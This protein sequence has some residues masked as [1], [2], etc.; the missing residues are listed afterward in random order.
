MSD[1]KP[2]VRG[3][4]DIQKMRI[5]AGNRIVADFKSRI[6]QEPGEKE[7]EL[8][9]DSKKLLAEI[10]REYNL[11]TE[12]VIRV[13]P[14]RIKE[15]GQSIISSY[16]VFAIVN[17][18][19]RLYDMEKD[20][21][22]H[23]ANALKDYPVYNKFLSGVK[24]IGPA[25]AGVIISE[26]DIHKAKYPS[27][28]WM[29]SGLDVA[30]DGKGRSKRK[31]HLVEVEYETADGQIKKKKSITFNPFLKTKLLGVLG[32]SFL[33]SKSDY[34]GYFY[35]YRSR[36]QNHAI[37]KDTTDGHRKNMAIRYMIKRFLVDLHVAWRKIEGLPVSKEYSE[38]KLGM[39]HG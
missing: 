22:N 24:G 27:S 38:A 39:S 28:L 29:Y 21:F 8:S 34:S 35:S 10:R 32:P 7:E 20:T 36:M 11:I 16:V 37:Y 15:K 6:G 2:L 3:V 14:K 31:E 12:G 30:E 5:Q 17:Y 19:M 13:S 9:S 4:Y 25:M 18:Y 1:L 33:K 23:L 26:I